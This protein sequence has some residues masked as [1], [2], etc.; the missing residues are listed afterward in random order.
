MNS[1]WRISTKKFSTAKAKLILPKL[2]YD[3]ADLEPI[4]SKEQIELHHSKHH[5]AYIDNYNK[6]IDVMQESINKGDLEK[7]SQLTNDLKFNGGSH[8]NHS[9]FWKSLSPV[10]SIIFFF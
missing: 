10:K 4:F 2:D 3:Y 1:L 7:I 5:Q 6:M 8:I 9:I